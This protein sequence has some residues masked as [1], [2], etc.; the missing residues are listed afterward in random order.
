[1][2]APSVQLDVLPSVGKL[3][4]ILKADWPTIR[5]C[6]Q[7]TVTL[8]QELE[9]ALDG[10]CSSDVS[11]V[12]FGSIARGEAT[13]ASDADWSLLVDGQA[14]PEH[15][16]LAQKVG[17]LIHSIVGKDPG[18]EGVFGNLA[19]SHDLIQLIGG[20]D[21]T[22]QNLTRRNLLLLE[23]RPFGNADA[24][25]RTLTQVLHRYVHE[26]LNTVKSQRQFYVPRF[27][28][29]DFA[30]FW[31]TMAVDFA[32]KR[33]DRVSKGAALRNAKLQM[34]RKLLFASGLIGCFACE[35]GL[36]G[37]ECGFPRRPDAERCQRCLL[38]FFRN[39]P[40]E[41]LAQAFLR[42]L[43]DNSKD[44]AATACKIFGAY[45]RFLSLLDDGDKR[46]LLDGLPDEAGVQVVAE[47][48][49]QI[50]HEFRDG[51]EELFFSTNDRLTNLVKRYGV[52]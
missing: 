22:N 7:R 14:D 3:E 47:E 30:R 24:Y 36:C 39:P 25:E 52:F 32:Y 46:K 19:F 44:G 38:P 16:Q 28:L 6:R 11:V 40:L 8:W 12:L 18:R 48:A 41:N 33:R 50:G 51:L 34:S 17:K 27:L 23:S 9:S 45:D 31:R 26:D 35:L 21:D 1:M 13:S 15:P 43:S 42:F 49:R 20:E 37:T 2:A 10:T 29:N 5:A 4:T